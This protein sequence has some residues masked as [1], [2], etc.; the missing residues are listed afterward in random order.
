MPDHA[1]RPDPDTRP[2]LPPAARAGR[3][4]AALCASLLGACASVPP[5]PPVPPP[6]AAHYP[7]PAEPRGAIAPP[8]WRGYFTTPALQALIAQA[9]D[10]N[11]DLR[12]AALRVREARAAYGL[13]AGAALPLLAAE[14]AG[15]R[16]RLP[17]DLH[18]TGAAAVSAQ[19][20]AGLGVGEWEL[21]LWGRLASE[22]EAARADVLA[23]DAARRAVAIGLI[24]Q[25]ADG[26]FALRELD[27]RIALAQQTLTTRR[28]SY[29]I[30]DRRAAVGATSRLNLTQVATLLLQAQGL[31]AQLQQERD[32][33]RQALQQLVGA[34]LAP[35]ALADDGANVALPPLAAGLPSMLLTRRADIMA[36]EQQLAAAHANVGAARAAFFPQV[37]LTGAL[38][39]ASAE[40][41]NLFGA[42][43][44]VWRYAPR[45]TV[46][47]FDGGRRRAGLAL[48][49]ARRDGAVAR[50]EKTIQAA[51][52]EVSDALSARVWLADQLAVAERAVQVQRER[53]RLSQLRF[54]NGAAPFLDVLD[55]QRELL[56]SEQQL[57]QL[58]R[59]MLSAGVALYAALGGDPAPDASF[60]PP[61]P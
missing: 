11:R 9:L 7:M 53:A 61:L 38:G 6:L 32:R 40:L 12:L 8:P 34:P 51:F 52:R 14:A 22:R 33:Q 41:S 42:G 60:P 18:P 59:A 26:Y 23:S 28:E 55:A 57:A 46:P 45:I 58:Q 30:F 36:A 50:Y 37:T 29:R 20:Q 13:A 16:Q 47:L 2:T 17:A 15:Q 35:G 31:T 48:A 1:R 4:R 3:W 27:Q 19:Y 21:D 25:V 5:P 56:A 54:D 24:T 49:E 43:S 44:G 39:N 10:N